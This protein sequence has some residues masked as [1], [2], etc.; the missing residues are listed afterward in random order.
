MISG[1]EGWTEV[2]R[3][4]TA[5]FSPGALPTKPRAKGSILDLFEGLE[6]QPQSLEEW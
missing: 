6:K 1:G 3:H 4:V 5:T 2:G